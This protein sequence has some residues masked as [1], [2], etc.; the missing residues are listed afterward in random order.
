M[1]KAQPMDAVQNTGKKPKGGI[2]RKL[3][4]MPQ[5]LGIVLMVVILVAA[6]YVG[7]WRTLENLVSDADKTLELSELVEERAAAVS[8]LLSIASRYPGVSESSVDALTQSRQ[9]LLDAEGAYD[10]SKADMSVQDGMLVLQNEIK[11]QSPSDEDATMV[12]RA[13]D[14]FYGVGNRMRQEARNYNRL[15]EHAQQVQSQLPF[16]M[17]LPEPQGY[18][19]I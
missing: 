15:I 7:N 18:Q 19:G 10:I 17:L 14:T 3:H 13:M 5:V 1:T 12:Q 16:G 8:N 6:L 11:K 4:E 2:Y 9:K